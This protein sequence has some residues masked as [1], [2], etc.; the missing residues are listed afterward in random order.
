V[1]DLA[2]APSHRFPWFLPDGRHF[3]Y[4]VLRE[5][6]DR[7]E[8]WWGSLGTTATEKVVVAGSNALY[9]EPGYLV[10]ARGASLLAEAFDA[11]ALR[12]VGPPVV[13]KESVGVYGEEGPTGLGAFSAS[14]TGT[15]AVTDV[16]WPPL[17]FAWFDRKGRRLDTVGQPDD[18]IAFDLSPDGR[19][20]A[21][22]RFDARKRSSDV[23]TID[24]RSGVQ[25]QITDDPWP[26]AGV[27]WA[28]TGTRLAFSSLRRGTWTAFVR[29][30]M[31]RDAEREV[32]PCQS[33]DGWVP[34]GRHVLCERAS[35]GHGSLWEVPLDAH[36]AVT[37]LGLSV[38]DDSQSRISPDGRWLAYAVDEDDAQRHIRVV[39]LP[40][41]RASTWIPLGLGT[42]PRWRRDGRE[43]FFLAGRSLV[44][45]PVTTDSPASVGRAVRLFEAPLRRR[46]SL[47]D[48]QVQF[49][50]SADGARFLF[51]V[52]VEDE[53]PAP[54]HVVP[55]RLQRLSAD[56]QPL[57]AGSGQ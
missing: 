29:E 4:L 19:R 42:S 30:T 55:L 36:D 28:P 8:I 15:L 54:V 56:R 37:P 48:S 2:G 31:R 26:D 38:S 47:S 21:A 10:F 40:R 44:A 50:V 17:R 57:R 7:S 23:V 5:D 12:L 27:A 49:C 14:P 51:A 45:V 3:L 20:V 32:G 24:L 46:D 13:L 39:R 1:T 18:Y 43:L 53:P 16:P 25:T 34:N 52:P 22:V 41:T 33:M 6:R 11:S 35:D 9:V